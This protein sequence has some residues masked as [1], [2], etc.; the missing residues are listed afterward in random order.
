MGLG[1]TVG[2][3]LCLAVVGS[4]NELASTS[5][6]ASFL[7]IDQLSGG[8][9]GDTVFQSDVLTGGS[10][11]EDPGTLTARL[12]LKDP[13]PSASP[14]TPS[15]VNFITIDRFRVVYVRTDGGAVPVPFEGAM[16]FTVTG[17]AASA[18]F[19]LVRASAKLAP[20][21]LA[22]RNGGGLIYTVAE[23]SFFGRDQTGTEIITTGRITVNFADWADP[24]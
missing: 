13:G 14:A 1:R 15:S 6:A 17:T 4:C 21:L 18:N 12:A 8:T 9:E 19:T 24:P 16:T 7:V 5:R 2:L 11:F 3:A 23:V 10:I 20:P 22:L